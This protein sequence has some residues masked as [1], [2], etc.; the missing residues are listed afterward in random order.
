MWQLCEK[1]DRIFVHVFKKKKKKF[2]KLKNHVFGI[3]NMIQ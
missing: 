3:I 1:P 2:E